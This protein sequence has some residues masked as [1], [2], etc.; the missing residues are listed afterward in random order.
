MGAKI[1]WGS[2][3]NSSR[4]LFLS[5]HASKHSA[6]EQKCNSSHTRYG[7]TLEEEEE[8]KHKSQYALL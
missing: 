4:L 3:A 5:H 8:K 7:V 6:K 1:Y 2:P